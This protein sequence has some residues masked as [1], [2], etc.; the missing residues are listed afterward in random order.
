[1]NRFHKKTIYEALGRESVHPFPAR[2]APGIA[3]S[4][5]ADM[6]ESLVLDPMM[7]SGTVLAMAR[8]NG[9]RGI[10][11]DIDPLAVLISKVWTTPIDP[12]TIRGEAE[13]VLE[14]AWQEFKNLTVA[15]A[16][17]MDADEETGRFIRYWFDGYARRQLAALSMTIQKIKPTVARNALWCA[18]SRLIISKQS[19]AS[20]AMDLS[21]SR[22]HRTFDVAPEKPFNK[23]LS[24][25]ELI[26]TNTIDKNSEDVGLEPAI[27][28][29]DAREMPLKDNS[30]DL[31]LTSPPYLN[32]IDYVRCSKFSLVWMGYQIADLRQ[33][34]TESVGTE[35]ADESLDDDKEVRTIIDALKLRPK[36][37]KRF[38][39]ILGR[40]IHDM[41]GA[42]AEV[43]R[44]LSKAGKAVYVVGE[45]TLRGTYIRTSVIVTKLAEL[46][47]LSM[48][49]RRRRTLPAN[50]RYMPPP[51]AAKGMM[52]GR[53]RREVVLSFARA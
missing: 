25:V 13:S 40:Y 51:S 50:R 47:G 8:A 53:M 22:P 19:G 24:A 23:F 37:D 35:A 48:K 49:E 18:F 45:N 43:G 2:M 39:R 4:V 15:D 10:G 1:M 9:H 44:V 17:P 30:V 27:K 5:M 36:L 11:F 6:D 26:I 33:V 7:G 34:R 46:A 31:V 12:K 29:G 38:E 52:D 41:R 28:M 21:H 42:I 20:R 32:A 3:L 14:D 16:Y